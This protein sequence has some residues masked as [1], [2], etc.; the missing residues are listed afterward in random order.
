VR[1]AHARY[2][3]PDNLRFELAHADVG[4]ADGGHSPG[5]AP[6]IA[7]EH[8]QRP[9]IDAVRCH[10]G[11]QEFAQA[12]EVRAAMG[13]HDAFG[14]ARGARGVVDGDRLV[15]VLEWPVE[16]VWAA[17]GQKRLVVGTRKSHA[18]GDVLDVDDELEI[19][20]AG[21]RRLHQVRELGIDDE[22][23]GAGVLQDVPHLGRR[24]ARVDGHENCPGQRNREVALQH[25]WDVGNQVGD[26]IAATDSR[27]EQRG[28]QAVDPLRDLWIGP[29]PV[30]VDDGRLLPEDTGAPLQKAQRRQM[31]AV[32]L[33][34]KHRHRGGI[35]QRPRA[36]STRLVPPAYAS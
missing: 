1:H 10:P 27:A 3:L 31:R 20:K 22:D 25:R 34:R 14:A 12:V 29:D 30:A 24:Q 15:L 28:G 13:V 16:R 11:F 7:M 2:Q 26:P 33:R 21:E 17:G 32:D 19:G 36:C 23:L 18:S 6:A 35:L 8:R 9:E 4:T 5:V